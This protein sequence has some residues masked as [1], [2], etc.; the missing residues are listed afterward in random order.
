MAFVT[1]G[2]FTGSRGFKQGIEIA[3]F[4]QGAGQLIETSAGSGD[5]TVAG[6]GFF[7]GSDFGIDLDRFA[8]A[9]HHVPAI[10]HG[11]DD[12]CAITGDDGVA[13]ANDIAGFQTTQIACAVAGI[14]FASKGGNLGNNVGLGHDTTP[15]TMGDD[16]V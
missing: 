16:L 13:L 1:G 7:L 14:S 4:G 8:F 9:D 15:D 12:L 11:Q 10:G 5:R 3:T 6:I 2:D